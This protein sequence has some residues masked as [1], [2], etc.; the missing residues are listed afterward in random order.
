MNKGNKGN[1]SPN[2]SDMQDMARRLKT[3][4]DIAQMVEELED[5][6]ETQLLLHK[7][8]VKEFDLNKKEYSIF[9]L[10]YNELEILKQLISERFI[11][12]SLM[13]S[14]PKFPKE[15]EIIS[16]FIDDKDLTYDVILTG[17]SEDLWVINLTFHGKWLEEYIAFDYEK[18][19]R[20]DLFPSSFLP[21]L[22]EAI[23]YS[24]CQDEY[25]GKKMKDKVREINSFMSQHQMDG[26]KNPK[27]GISLLYTPYGINRAIQANKNIPNMKEYLFRVFIDF[28][29]SGRRPTNFKD[30]NEFKIFII[31]L[32][33][34]YSCTRSVSKRF[35]II[36]NK[37]AW[38]PGLNKTLDILSSKGLIKEEDINQTLEALKEFFIDPEDHEDQE[39]E[40]SELPDVV[41][42]ISKMFGVNPD[43]IKSFPLGKIELPKENETERASCIVKGPE[44]SLPS[45]KPRKNTKEKKEKGKDKGESDERKS[46]N[47]KPRKT[48]SDKK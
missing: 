36:N 30:Y 34:G 38:N 12:V 10:S 21:I 25:I 24:W 22:D 29:N 9:E 46:K 41:E 14:L 13:S 20:T 32:L 16:N 8:K 42:L 37:F 40:K 28:K 44:D 35:E 26:Y 3:E 47:N 4:N 6:N 48:K 27:I 15:D 17:K 33:V 43:E 31:A 5:L 2:M 45:I 7:F 1:R 18:E 39:K 11:F 23:E 19:D